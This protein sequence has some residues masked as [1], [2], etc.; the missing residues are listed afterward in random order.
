MTEWQTKRNEIRIKVITGGSEFTPEWGVEQLR[1][2]WNRLGGEE[3][4]KLVNEWYQEN[5]ATFDKYS[6]K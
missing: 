5:K 4:N 3:V 6:K 2:E 1:A